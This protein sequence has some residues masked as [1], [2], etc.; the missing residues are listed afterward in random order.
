MFDEYKEYKTKS[1]TALN[2]LLLICP[3]WIHSYMVAL[4]VSRFGQKHAR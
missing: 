2:V 1:M 4:I 3:K